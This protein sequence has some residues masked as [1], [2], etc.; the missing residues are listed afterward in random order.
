MLLIAGVGTRGVIPSTNAMDLATKTLHFGHGSLRGVRSNRIAVLVEN[1]HVYPTVP[2][3]DT[4]AIRI[5]YG[6][7]DVAFV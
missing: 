5:P 4:R 7:L 3:G 6:G 2:R 1:R